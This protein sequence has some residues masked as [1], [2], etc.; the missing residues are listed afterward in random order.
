M[1]NAAA[2]W[3]GA[4]GGGDLY[5]VGFEKPLPRRDYAA[6]PQRK[7]GSSQSLS[8]FFVSEF[9]GTIILLLIE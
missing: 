7:V 3:G 1:N 9:S 6:V 8:S 2:Y 5:G 4:A